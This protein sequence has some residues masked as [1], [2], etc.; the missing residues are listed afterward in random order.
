MTGRAG[1]GLL[2][3]A[4]RL[5]LATVLGAAGAL[6]LLPLHGRL[7]DF[8]D[9]SA[10]LLL[11]RS[12]ASGQGFSALHAPGSPPEL[13]YPPLFPAL[14]APIVALSGDL[15]ALKLVG[16]ASSLATIAVVSLWLRRL[17]SPRVALFGAAYLALSPQLLLSSHE[18]LSEPVFTLLAAI[19]LW[20]A[21]RPEPNGWLVGAACAAA[22]L[23][24]KVG[25]VFI[26]CIALCWVLERETRRA[27]RRTLLPL[28]V[29][30]LGPVMLWALRERLHGVPPD[31]VQHFAS[32]VAAPSGTY[33]PHL[34]HHVQVYA[35]TLASLAVPQTT[36]L[37]IAER[38]LSVLP[39]LLVAL[40]L[41]SALRRRLGVLVLVLA[42]WVGTFLLWPW[43]AE[44]FMLPM[45]PV[46]VV[47]LMLLPPPGRL[48]QALWI[49]LGVATIAQV[50]ETVQLAL[51]M[52]G[53]QTLPF[54]GVDYVPGVERARA[55]L[56]ADA[57]VC[58][59]E[60]RFVTYATGRPSIECAV[61]L[62]PADAIPGLLR[63]SGASHYIHDPTFLRA[64]LGQPAEDP[65]LRAPQCF[66]RVL[67]QGGFVLH[68][69]AE[70]CRAP[71]RGRDPA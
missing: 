40:G 35:P 68:R 51:A 18:I 42:A 33:F 56:P 46:L 30:G 4:R 28:L 1:A 54:Y 13:N 26:P 37:V 15:R 55:V 49:A 6:Y 7:L 65:A 21:T 29:L 3:R 32:S 12:L 53:E 2:E 38:A 67:Q 34:W 47:A 14:L 9:S 50:P 63:Q 59:P 17:T 45:L 52:R 39:L 71:A 61:Y 70:A 10:Y 58:A 60:P 41:A 69:I 66:V 64:Y 43:A 27:W 44:R 23:T 20:Q 11:A 22:C 31:H 19:A 62:A 16:I 48:G 57:L 25:G 36:R 8:Q 24:R 5:P